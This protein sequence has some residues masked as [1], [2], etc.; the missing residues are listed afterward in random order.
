MSVK[1][2]KYSSSA[3]NSHNLFIF[4]SGG[5]DIPAWKTEMQQTLAQ[6][7][8]STVCYI[9][10]S[11]KKNIW[12]IW[13][14]LLLPCGSVT[15]KNNFKK[16]RKWGLL[17]KKSKFQSACGSGTVSLV[18]ELMQLYGMRV[19]NQGQRFCITILQGTPLTLTNHF[20]TILWKDEWQTD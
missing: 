18:A 15:S 4:S 20:V 9:E 7:L 14:T 16:M 12:K 13:D 17:W 19:L 5:M 1:I 3:V 6:G 11:K 10:L 2:N 8:T